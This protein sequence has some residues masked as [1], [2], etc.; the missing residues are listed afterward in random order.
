M[1]ARSWLS[2]AVLLLIL[3]CGCSGS[4]GELPAVQG[5]VFR[6]GQ[7]LS[8][9]TIV[10]TPDPE[11]GGGSGPLAVGEIDAEG[12][13]TL[14]TQGKPGAVAGWHRVTIAPPAPNDGAS[15]AGDLPGRYRD[16]ERSGLCR[17]VKGGQANTIDIN[18]E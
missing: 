16:P 4:S 1:S 17:E 15:A 8:G 2:W 10:F 12:H 7:P 14:H 13:Y 11:H 9:G 5:R 6:H 18:L 3:S